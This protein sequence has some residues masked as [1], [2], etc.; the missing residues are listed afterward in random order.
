MRQGVLPKGCSDLKDAIVSAGKDLDASS[1]SSAEMHGARNKA[2]QGLRGYIKQY[3]SEYLD[4][5]LACKGEARV[6]WLLR[7]LQDAES[8]GCI[9]KSSPYVGNITRNRFRKFWLT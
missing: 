1:L 2:F 9:A 4:E 6:A 7:F 5:Y 8:G 3:H